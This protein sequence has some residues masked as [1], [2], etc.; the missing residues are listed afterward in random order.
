M[1]YGGDVARTL[2]AAFATSASVHGGHQ[3]K[4]GF[5][6]RMCIG[7]N[8]RGIVEMGTCR[9]AGLAAALP[10]RVDNRVHQTPSFGYEREDVSDN[11]NKAQLH[12]YSLSR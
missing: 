1:I 4:R 2:I 9:R 12:D 7:A 3:W 10:S 5:S 8:V 6:L 11:R